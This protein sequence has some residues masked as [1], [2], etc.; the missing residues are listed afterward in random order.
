MIPASAITMKSATE[1]KPGEIGYYFTPT[2]ASFVVGLMPDDRVY[3]AL[4][5]D[6]PV[7][8]LQTTNVTGP[9]AIVSG[10]QI[11]VD[12]H[13]GRK[14]AVGTANGCLHFSGPNR[15]L[16]LEYRME[17]YPLALAAVAENHA[18]D[19]IAFERWCIVL[20]HDGAEFEIL[21]RGP[22]AE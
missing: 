4:F 18:G 12:I 1:L 11:E 7:R 22:V 15:F 17:F 20:R 2:P 6:D 16:E 9:V 14:A 10:A 3:I 19:R 8:V 13:S 21:S 5:S